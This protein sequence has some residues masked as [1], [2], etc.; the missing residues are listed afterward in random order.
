MKTKLAIIL[1]LFTIM[2]C[3]KQNVS[4]EPRNHEK[5]NNDK[6]LYDS[7]T[8]RWNLTIPVYKTMDETSGIDG[9]VSK[10]INIIDE[11]EIDNIYRIV[12]ND[13]IGFID[14]SKITKNEIYKADTYMYNEESVIAD[15]NKDIIRIGPKL[16]IKY[17]DKKIVFKDIFGESKQKRYS[18][19]GVLDNNNVII[20]ESCFEGGRRFIYDLDKEKE[21]C[22]I[23]SQIL[24]SPDKSLIFSL[25]SNYV[26]LAYSIIAI[27]S[28]KITSIFD[29]PLYDQKIE[30][31]NISNTDIKWLANDKVIISIPNGNILISEENKW[32]YKINIFQEE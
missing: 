21:I 6:V 30:D 23:Y 22:N 18:V 4:T 25:G 8:Y 17:N 19:V 3:H 12:F 31:I 1:F 9:Y 32:N 14:F 27:R 29:G 28:G 5:S 26:E 16:I 15:Q 24:W 7:S 10:F 20:Q 2:S 13:N 11:T